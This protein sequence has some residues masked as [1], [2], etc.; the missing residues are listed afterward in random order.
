[1]EVEFMA[2]MYGIGAFGCAGLIWLLGLQAAI[3]LAGCRA[4][5]RAVAVFAEPEGSPRGEPDEPV[6]LALYLSEQLSAVEQ[7]L[8][9]ARQANRLLERRLWVNRPPVATPLTRTL[10]RFGLTER[11]P[12]VG[13]P[14]LRAA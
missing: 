13:R 11:H 3:E 14:A 6:G 1:M 9:D 2:V 10:N 8:A 4:E 12:I 5:E 7:A